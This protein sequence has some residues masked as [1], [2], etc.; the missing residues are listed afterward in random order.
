MTSMSAPPSPTPRVLGGLFALALICSLAVWAYIV[1]P[2][3]G[4]ELHGHEAHGGLLYVHAASGS[5]ML[6]LG[7][8][9]LYVGWTRRF[10]RWHKWLGGGYLLSGTLASV[11]ALA[12]PLVATHE[13]GSIAVARR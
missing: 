2:V 6:F 4:G 11:L 10:F 12:L 1:L 8:A 7:A 5:S 3:L 9:A 13:P